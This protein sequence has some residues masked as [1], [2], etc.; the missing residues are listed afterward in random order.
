MFLYCETPLLQVEA[1]VP[2]KAAIQ[3]ALSTFHD[4]YSVICAVVK[5]RQQAAPAL[6]QTRACVLT[7]LRRPHEVKTRTRGEG[8]EA[9]AAGPVGHDSPR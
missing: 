1:A 3:S 9:R 5:E 4:V 6:H 8:T 2:L 7:T